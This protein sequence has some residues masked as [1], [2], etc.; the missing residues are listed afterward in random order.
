MF[1][2]YKIIKKIQSGTDADAENRSA[3]V[4]EMMELQNME[5]LGRLETWRRGVADVEAVS[6]GTSVDGEFITPT[7]AAM[8]GMDVTTAHVP[9]DRRSMCQEDASVTSSRRSRRSSRDTYP[10]THA[11]KENRVEVPARGSSRLFRS[12]ST[13][14]PTRSRASSKRT[15]SRAGSSEA[16]SGNQS[17]ERDKDKR[18][19]EKKKKKGPS[20]LR[21]MFTP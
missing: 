14:A 3:G 19:K 1:G 5:S 13:K 21:L 10:N 11:H 6:V 2:G 7:A 17:S 4:D 12:E 16:G 20:R 8:S 18:S 15:T 9:R